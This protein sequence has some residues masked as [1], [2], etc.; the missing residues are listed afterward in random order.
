MR[1]ARRAGRAEDRTNHESDHA[2]ARPAAA[3]RRHGNPDGQPHTRGDHSRRCPARASTLV[4]R[5]R[6]SFISVSRSNRAGSISKRT[7][8]RP[9]HITGEPSA[10]A[11]HITRRCHPHASEESKDTTTQFINQPTGR[12]RRTRSRRRLV[13]V[14]ICLRHSTINYNALLSLPFVSPL[15]YLRHPRRHAGRPPDM[16]V[17]SARS[18]PPRMRSSRREPKNAQAEG[19]VTPS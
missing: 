3:R 13:H 19:D 11:T 17:A 6:A 14:A 9:A 1:L 12:C 15:Q 2:P 7:Q 4:I 16:V 8:A 10:S 5:H 18:S